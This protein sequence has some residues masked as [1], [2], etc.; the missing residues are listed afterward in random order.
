MTD[1]E[2]ETHWS[3]LGSE[4]GAAPAPEPSRHEAAAPPEN[5]VASEPTEPADMA[6]VESAAS[7]HDP[8]PVT[9][10]TPSVSDEAPRSDWSGLADELGVVATDPQVPPAGQASVP[11][12]QPPD[13]PTPHKTKPRTDSAPRSTTR[14]NWSGLASELGVVPQTEP[15]AATSD[16]GASVASDTVETRDAAPSEVADPEAGFEE[17]RPVEGVQMTT[18]DSTADR[19]T[20]ERPES[21]APERRRRRG[22]RGGSRKRSSSDQSGSDDESTKSEPDAEGSGQE[23][24]PARE[25]RRRRRSRRTASPNRDR[26][27]RRETS[28]R[29]TPETETVDA[30]SESL[31]DS[32]DAE[33]DEGRQQ[34]HRKIPSWEEAVGLVVNANLE[35]RAK[36]P[37][38]EKKTGRSRGRPRTS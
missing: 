2:R 38:G 5:D 23:G 14:S 6:P 3:S 32:D 13:V 19:P 29:T 37:Q 11:A 8:A 25:P 17:P 26:E 1:R 15:T 20:Q 34:K 27:E 16:L 36:S 30:G 7:V 21:K 24:E 33:S 9:D 28:E 12:V 31:T 22:S 18:V 4:L 35:S 10:V